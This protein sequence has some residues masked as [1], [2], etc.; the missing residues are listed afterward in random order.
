LPSPSITTTLFDFSF[1]NASLNDS[2]LLRQY[3]HLIALSSPTN[4]RI[5]S[6]HI[7]RRAFYTLLSR[8]LQ[9]LVDRS[10]HNNSTHTS[11][12]SHPENQHFPSIRSKRSELQSP[13]VFLQ[14]SDHL[15]QLNIDGPNHIAS[16]LP[17][18]HVGRKRPSLSGPT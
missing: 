12:R 17:H 9:V 8:E 14:I 13:Q 15:L 2:T 16:R 11:E 3:I 10:L 5:Q 18:S 4:R 7:D 6:Y 1:A